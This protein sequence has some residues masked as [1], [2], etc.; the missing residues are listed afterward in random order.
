MG[1]VTKC[2][3][4]RRKRK[5][6]VISAPTKQH[7]LHFRF[8]SFWYKRKLKLSLRRLG[9]GEES[10]RMGNRTAAEGRLGE[11]R[12]G[13]GCVLGLHPQGQ[14]V[15]EWGRL[16]VEG[17]WCAEPLCSVADLTGHVPAPSRP[18]MHRRLQALDQAPS[19]RV[20][21]PSDQEA[22]QHFDIHPPHPE[23]ELLI[24]QPAQVTGLA[25]RLLPPAFPFRAVHGRVFLSFAWPWG[26]SG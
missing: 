12:G 6:L 15:Q 21:G 8:I 18:H 13:R 19:L 4:R 3:E 9:V 24:L 5:P 16:E 17:C 25:Q 20:A 14:R 2:E 26:G 11:Q 10:S 22:G 1:R 23:P 7:C